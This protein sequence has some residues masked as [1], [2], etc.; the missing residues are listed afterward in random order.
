MVSNKLFTMLMLALVYGSDVFDG[1]TE[2]SESGPTRTLERAESVRRVAT[3]NGTVTDGETG[4][5]VKQFRVI[6]GILLNADPPAPRFFRESATVH[7]DGRFGVKLPPD[8]NRSLPRFSAWVLRLEAEGYVPVQTRAFADLKGDQPVEMQ[9]RPGR[10]PGGTVRLADGSPA[11]GA[12]LCIAIPGEGPLIRHGRLAD[13][14]SC[15]HVEADSEGRFA[16]PAQSGDFAV[17]V[18]HKKGYA[19]VKGAS[20][21]ESPKI[22]LQPWARIEGVCLDGRVPA[23][24][25]Y[26]HPR[27]VRDLGPHLGLKQAW[28][29]PFD[30]RTRAD[31]EGQFALEYVVPG[32]IDIRVHQVKDGFDTRHGG[33]LW[34]TSAETTRFRIGDPGP[35]VTGRIVFPE[36]V[37]WGLMSALEEN[38]FATKTR[39]PRRPDN[40]ATMSVA[41]RDC[42]NAAFL[43]TAEGRAY[44]E[45]LRKSRWFAVVPNQDG[46][47]SVPNVPPGE[48]ELRFG[49]RGLGGT[50]DRDRSV[51]L[52]FTVPEED[53]KRV[54]LGQIRLE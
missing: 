42:W 45:T 32:E 37:R 51:T 15:Q 22:T 30:L 33:R 50:K 27:V 54:E 41:E 46:V 36:G 8:W 53:V 47:F 4:Q 48:Y 34:A 49:M 7:T 31:E 12:E 18:L 25:V 44:S 9:L 2:S 26:I 19:D 6:P 38:C 20:L 14:E 17:I 24:K 3:V 35:T 29:L 23:A 11:A 52:N 16:L 13:P 43:E 1:R 39:P 28:L 5:P 10:G 40:W 21:R